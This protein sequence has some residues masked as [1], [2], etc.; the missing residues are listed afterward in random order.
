MTNIEYSKSQIQSWARMGSRATYGQGLLMLAENFSELIAIS[1]D[2]GNSSGLDRFKASYPERFIN[3]GIAEQNMIGVAAGLAK[4]G[5]NVFASSFAPFIAFRASEQV[6]MNMGYMELGVKA[7]GI[8]S[9]LSMNFLGNSHFGIEDISIM[10]SIPN[11]TVV[12]PCDTTSV[13][14]VLE[15]AMNYPRPMYIR[16]TGAPGDPVVYSENFDFEIG[17]AIQLRSGSDVTL[18]ASGSSVAQCMYAASVLDEY[19]VS[20]TVID[21][22][23]IKPIDGKCLSEIIEKKVPIYAVEEHS[24]IG[25]LGSAISDWIIENEQVATLRKIALPDSYGPTG[26]YKFLKELYGLTGELIALR[27]M[28]DLK[29]N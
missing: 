14:K 12:S 15:S 1:A 23:T 28:S 17:R 13:I 21:L 4:E 9:G 18:I 11:M 10:R 6:R 25:G 20:S 27:I 7:V 19:G 24:K 3:V 2:L 16:L 5:F 22:H 8:G 29:I 26:D